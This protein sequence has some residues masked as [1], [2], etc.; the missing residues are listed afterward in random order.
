MREAPAFV[1][2][3]S[4]GDPNHRG[5]AFWQHW[6]QSGWRGGIGQDVFDDTEMVHDMVG[7]DGHVEGQLGLYGKWTCVIGDPQLSVTT[8][9]PNGNC[10][11]RPMG[12]AQYV[13]EVAMSGDVTPTLFAYELYGD[14]MINTAA[15]E[16]VSNTVAC[17]SHGRTTGDA[18]LFNSTGVLATPLQKFV[19]YFAIVVDGNTLKLAAT[20]ADALAGVALDLGGVVSGV[21]YM[22]RDLGPAR[23]WHTHNGTDWTWD[24]LEEFTDFEHQGITSA[25]FFRG[26][27][28]FGTR[29]GK[30]WQYNHNEPNPALVIEEM[31]N[32]PFVAGEAITAMV[33][34]EGRLYASQDNEV[35]SWDGL[36]H[37]RG[38]WSTNAVLTADVHFTCAA[39]W[40][41]FM[42][43]GGYQSFHGKLYRIDKAAGSEVARFD[44]N[45]VLQ[46]LAVYDGSLF[47]GGAQYDEARARHTGKVYRYGGSSLR[48][49]D[50]GGAGAG[51]SQQYMHGIWDM[52]EWNERLLLPCA[53]FQGLLVYDA[54]EDAFERTSR[55]WDAEVVDDD[56]EMAFGIAVWRG[57][58]YMNVPKWGLFRYDTAGASY[59]PVS[60]KDYSVE[61]SRYDA[62]LELVDKMFVDVTFE[63]ERFAAA[64]SIKAYYRT[65]YHGAWTEL[66]TVTAASP[67]LA[68]A[69]PVVAKFLQWRFDVLPGSGTLDPV[70]KGYRTRYVLAPQVRRNWSMTLVC[71]DSIELLDGTFEADNGLALRDHAWLQRVTPQFLYFRDTD[72]REFKV[73]LTQLAE[74]QPM[75]NRE[76]G[77]ESEVAIQL[78][79][80]GPYA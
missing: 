28:Y 68:F 61:T 19:R 67:S 3:F 8:G 75:T 60:G 78:W 1:E 7:L 77:F 36:D 16:G 13:D 64:D 57:V 47:I 54:K 43:W 56:Y 30:I 25:C 37:A 59:N 76:D 79:E 4:T 15:F 35:Y 49:L 11:Y 21:H 17:V 80:V 62:G 70:I 45:F 26:K 24:W 69:S 38:N 73:L 63:L 41:G 20:K 51:G 14:A 52:G 32:S 12:F 71:T 29:N 72:G 44:D 9:G 65:T 74:W 5:E 40:N 46:S 53:D 50:I 34:Y 58:P 18:V 23:V 10:P 6:D 48:A 27:M 55:C 31:V 2:R 33:A 39:V 66:G 22:F 42:W